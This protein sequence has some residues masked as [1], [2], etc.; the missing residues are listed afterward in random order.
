MA[1][2]V[3]PGLTQITRS[4]LELRTARVQRLRALRAP[5]RDAHG[6][7]QRAEALRA[8]IEELRERADVL[9]PELAD[10]RE[11]LAREAYLRDRIA[12]ACDLVEFAMLDDEEGESR[13]DD[14]DDACE[15]LALEW[16]LFV[17]TRARSIAHNSEATAAARRALDVASARSAVSDSIGTIDYDTTEVLQGLHQ[18]HQEAEQRLASARRGDRHARE[19]EVAEAAEAERQALEQAG[20]ASYTDFLMLR[21]RAPGHEASAQRM[22]SGIAEAEQALRDAAE[23]AQAAV[24]EHDAEEIELRARA[25]TLLGHLPGPDVSGDLRAMR[26]SSLVGPMVETP[27]A[28]VELASLCRQADLDTGPDPVATARAWLRNPSVI[29]AAAARLEAELAEIDSDGNKAFEE[30]ESL[31]APDA[32]D[33]AAPDAS[34]S[35]GAGNG[36]AS[37]VTSAIRGLLARG[38]LVPN[39]VRSTD[40]DPPVIGALREALAAADRDER[41]GIPLIAEFPWEGESDAVIGRMLAVFVDAAAARQVI[42]IAATTYP[43]P[44]HGVVWLDGATD[45]IDTGASGE[46]ALGMLDHVGA[47]AGSAG[48]DDDDDGIDPAPDAGGSGRTRRWATLN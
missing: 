39:T 1:L 30:L 15:R 17:A 44:V 21:V 34:V 8:S 32:A 18:A 2:G 12:V 31:Q 14:D 23:F 29:G 25:A 11:R 47:P 19:R 22:R 43:R 5:R 37:S 10:V 13:I 24:A 41:G 36:D 38:A 7:E 3:T 4:E 9:E 35:G 27:S 16:D 48:H 28:L 20:L 45:E 6:S 26:A 46:G 33:A 40:I 42:V